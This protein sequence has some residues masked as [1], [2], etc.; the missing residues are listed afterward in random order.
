MMKS[1]LLAKWMIG[2]LLA[3][4]FGLG[5]TIAMAYYANPGYSATIWD[6]PQSIYESYFKKP[7]APEIVD[8]Y[9]E[10]G[11]GA[12]V[13]WVDNALDEDGVRFYRRI[14][15]QPNFDAIKITGPHV[16]IPGSFDDSNLPVGTYEYRVGVFNEYGTSYSNI[17]EQV[18]IDNEVCGDEP[19]LIEPLNPVI[20]ALERVKDQEC[21]IRVYFNDNSTDEDG[22]RIYRSEWNDP[23]VLLADLPPNNT[24]TGSYDDVNVPPGHYTY[25]V[26]AYNENGE[27]FSQLSDEIEITE[28]ACG[29]LELGPALL[30]TPNISVISSATP[31]PAVQLQA[32]IWKAAINVFVRKGPGAS[33][34]PEIT[35]VESGAELKVVGQSE[36]GQFWAVELQPGV[37]GYVPKGERFGQAG[38]D[39]DVPTLPDPKAPPTPVPTRVPA[40]VPQCND[41][42]DNDGDGIVDMRDRGCSAPTD[43]SE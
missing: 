25:Q 14:V 16:G 31:T 7:K 22:I 43:N 19:L 1:G 3:G 18:V 26:S 29:G 24:S 10:G 33:I 21:T 27:A 38:G 11:C 28:E 30:I 8:Q 36:D 41:G 9:P 34:Y 32:C 23:D 4:L 17:S 2:I 35:A 12:R 40:S 20:T 6:Y 5:G 42:V 13:H 15:G 39:C 37:T